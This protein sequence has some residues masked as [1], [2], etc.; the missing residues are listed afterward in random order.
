MKFLIG[1]VNATSSFGKSIPCVTM[2]MHQQ[3]TDKKQVALDWNTFRFGPHQ[4]LKETSV[5]VQVF[6][7]TKFA[8]SS[9]PGSLV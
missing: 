1:V 3:F 8:S 5:C 4:L 6:E 7:L 9:F 2:Q